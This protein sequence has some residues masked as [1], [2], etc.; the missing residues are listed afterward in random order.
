MTSTETAS[1]SPATVDSE[2]DGFGFAAGSASNE[3]HDNTVGVELT[4][5]MR[6]QHIFGNG[7][8][9]AGAETSAVLGPAFGDFD[10]ANRIE[11]NSVGVDFAGTIQFNRIA[12]NATG[13]AAAD[14]QQI[15]H[16]LIYG[17]TNHGILTSAVAV[18]RIIQNTIY[19]ETGDAVHV[20]AGSREIEVRGN[21]LYARAGYAVFVD[22]AG[23]AGYFGDANAL[24]ASDAGKLYF[25]TKD[26]YD[27]LD[28]QA[29]VGRFELT[30]IGTTVMHPH[31]AEPAF[32]SIARADFAAHDLAANLRPTSPTIDTADP[33]TDFGRSP[34]RANLLVNGDFD[35]PGNPLGGWTTNAGA[36]G[37]SSEAF[38]GACAY[39]PGLDAQGFAEQEIDLVAAGHS[40]A[41]LD[42][43][44]LVVILGG[45]VNSAK[46]QTIDP[47]RLI[48]T[49]LDGAGQ[50]IGAPTTVFAQG[51]GDRFE[52]IGDRVTVPLGARKARL[53]F[54][55]ELAPGATQNVSFD[56]AF[57]YVEVDTLMPNHGAFG[58]TDDEAMGF[59]G[60][61]LI[62]RF[63]DLYTDW[64]R[65]KPRS[66]QWDSLGNDTESLVS[67][68]LFQ[69]GPHGPALLLHI[70][71]TPDDGQHTW[72]PFD[73]SGIDFGTHGLRIGVS[74]VGDPRVADWSI[75]P[76]SVP[77]DGTDYYVNVAADA[78]LIDNEYTTA[79]GSNRQTGKRPDAPK[80]NPVNV[81]R[82]Y[83]V[84]GGAN[85]S[86]DPGLYP[87]I[88]PIELSGSINHGLG[89]DRGFTL[90]GPTDAV[91]QLTPAN[92]VIPVSH[93]VLLDDA[94][95]T[96]VRQLT[97]TGGN[98][99]LEIIN[100]TTNSLI[101]DVTISGMGTHGV[102]IDN[103]YDDVLE[104]VTVTGNAG[105]LDDPDDGN[106]DGVHI[107]SLGDRDRR[108]TI[109]NLTST[110]NGRHGLYATF[111]FDEVL[112]INGAT[113]SGNN[114]HG[115]YVAG[116]NNTGVWNDLEVRDNYYGILSQGT[117]EIN[118]AA[119]SGNFTP[120]PPD[121]FYHSE[122]TCGSFSDNVRNTNS[123]PGYGIDHN[124]SFPI[125]IRDSVITGHY[126][127]VAIES[128]DVHDSIVRANYLGL[129]L[130]EGVV[131]GNVFTGNSIGL[132]NRIVMEPNHRLGRTYLSGNHGHDLEIRNNLI[133]GNLLGDPSLGIDPNWMTAMAEIFLLCPS[134]PR[135]AVREAA[136]AVETYGLELAAGRSIT[137]ALVLEN[138]TIDDDI[139]MTGF[140]ANSVT[141]RNNIFSAITTF[142]AASLKTID[143]N[144]Y[145]GAA[146]DDVR[147][148]V[149]DLHSLVGDPL[150]VDPA[151]GDY[152]LQSTS[153]SFNPVTQTFVPRRAQST[154]I[155]TGDPASDFSNEPAPN[156]GF[157]NLGAYGNTPE[158]SLSPAN[159]VTVTAPI[160]GDVVQ[161]GNTVTVEWR[162]FGFDG[163]VDLEYSATGA[164]GP[165]ASLA[166][167]QPNDG[168][169]D[170]FVDSS[171][172]ATSQQ[173]VLR[174]RSVDT[175]AVVGTSGTFAVLPESQNY[176]VNIAGDVNFADNEYTTAA[177]DAANTGLTPDSPKPSIQ[178]VLNAFVLE[179][180]DTIFVDT[181]SYL[182]TVTVLADD[183][184]V[185]VQ[186][187]VDPLHEAR[188]G[189]VVVQAAGVTLSHLAVRAPGG[190][191]VRI[192]SGANGFTLQNALVLDSTT[193]L[194]VAAAGVTGTVIRDSEMRNNTI[195]IDSLAAAVRVEDNTIYA[196]TATLVNDGIRILDAVGTGTVV[197]GNE[198]YKDISATGA[199]RGGT[200]IRVETAG[201]EV[202][203]NS[204]YQFSVAGLKLIDP[205]PATPSRSFD[206]VAH[207][208][209]GVGLL[210]DKYG[211][212]FENELRNSDVG[213]RLAGSFA[214]VAHDLDIS[215]NRIG[216]DVQKGELRDSRIYGNTEDGVQISF[217]VIA[218]RLN[219]GLATIHGNS[220]YSNATGIADRRRKLDQ[221]SF[222]GSSEAFD[223]SVVVRNNLI[224][225]HSQQAML[226]DNYHDTDFE[227][228]RIEN[229]T[230]YEPAAHG[231][232]LTGK[233]QNVALKN[234]II[235]IGGSG[236]AAVNVAAAAQLGFTSDYNLFHTTGGGH[237]GLWQQVAID[238]LLD[239]SLELGQDSHSIA[240]DPLFVDPHGV[241][242]LLGFTAGVTDGT[243][244]NFTLSSLGGSYHGGAWT[245]DAQHSP[246]IDAGDPASL[247]LE[248]S[249][250]GLPIGDPL[251]AQHG[252]RINLGA[253]GNTPLASR[254]PTN[255]IQVLSPNGREKHRVSTPANIQW[256]SFGDGLSGL[257][258]IQV[259][260]DGGANYQTVSAGIPDDGSFLWTPTTYS[261]GALVRV[262]DSTNAALADV[263]DAVFA[264]GDATTNYYVND[265]SLVGDEYTTAVGDNANTATRPSDPMASLGALLKAYSLTSGDRVWVDHGGY[266]ALVN[267]GFQTQHTGASVIGP[268]SGTA[269]LNR[270]N[271]NPRQYVVEI[272]G[273]DNVSI[274]GLDL[275]GGERGVHVST[276]ADGTLLDDLRVYGNTT[277]VF[278]DVT[279]NVT[280]TNSIVELNAAT[281][282]HLAADSTIAA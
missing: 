262:L 167:N 65:D 164:S 149:F 261:T 123:D 135:F 57:L 44:D 226:I 153:G 158:A 180:G 209:T 39:G 22:N 168:D 74:L 101:D 35:Q 237:V 79:P 211:E 172:F 82:M 252:G 177:G 233:S 98:N 75:E 40:L 4:G 215:Q 282:V 165:F 185:F 179:P 12:H 5:R 213:L 176:Y 55:T 80:P 104:G 19:A 163:N 277:G 243:D 231:I 102:F 244:D 51:A 112:D 254:S 175:P 278:A 189:A 257:V 45:R 212:H 29:D 16:N 1:V 249:P 171:L 151:G 90:Q 264:I 34:G 156:G 272:A 208:N 195:G 120:H 222:S 221:T 204:V 9:V 242:N 143:Y 227:T 197:A 170:W 24:L 114:S 2:V 230:I 260:Y 85:L 246:A 199:V 87:L 93:V 83:E 121:T 49:F 32:Q 47:G 205:T 270:G 210:V 145:A 54:Q 228:T 182:S 198:V 146:L 202:F 15:L 111:G 152:H 92:P 181:G 186:G 118:R 14:G 173:Y 46:S 13:I 23:Q 271:A 229:N 103:S 63:P 191:A 268:A 247:V 21:T 256:R 194:L 43:E 62:L 157:V 53:R 124:G 258:D 140:A 240:G 66:I 113:L 25:W 10:R 276:D 17:N 223:S 206:N 166:A 56:H 218:F 159:Y 67:I 130:N 132:T 207:S 234:N 78:D 203:A 71:T 216:A 64:E 116:F 245:A 219:F 109:N 160:A 38:I 70:A 99:T 253:Y 6:N 126:V 265:A 136:A 26:F 122:Y 255:V 137:G 147:G 7:T 60:P 108:L 42:S 241:D 141:A 11:H 127:G 129:L 30:S 115:L 251:A 279:G 117:I 107:E 250:D 50:P 169:F 81:L 266:T 76:F 52:L 239:W 190:V 73:D 188:F 48:L 214:G 161:H 193:G 110:G 8:G 95:F 100:G 68:D 224:Y 88:D 125:Q 134:P 28:L 86:I 36:V 31:W 18:V 154:A 142:P 275:T 119:I 131:A 128:G 274:A 89:L 37:C 248:D 281:G 280:L 187:P 263:S 41:D 94:D 235:Y 236:R 97:L 133:Y 200:G 273:A 84:T 150:F 91:G 201:F 232:V 192:E 220:I 225:D 269:T 259:S 139:K 27:L 267:V 3:I 217:E 58:Q 69:D 183:A 20:G 196:T 105:E 162:S 96:T 72:I 184:G 33:L 238:G 59:A 77:E 138:N 155:D 174:V 61:R 144:F 148:P 178:A 106:R